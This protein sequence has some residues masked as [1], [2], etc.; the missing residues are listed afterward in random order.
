MPPLYRYQII[1][2][3]INFVRYHIVLNKY[4]KNNAEIYFYEK[5]INVVGVYDS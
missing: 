1:K 3:K 2:I 4:T 5:G